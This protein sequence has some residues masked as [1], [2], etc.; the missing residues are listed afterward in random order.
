[1]PPRLALIQLLTREGNARDAVTAADAAQSALPGNLQVTSALGAAQLA[2]GNANQAVATFQRVVQA[3][4]QSAPALIR[5]AEAQAA[6]Q[7]IPNAI[8]ST[9]KAMA[10]QPNDPTAWLLLT[11]LMLVSG[12]PDDAIAEAR[13]LQ[14]EQPDRAFGYALEGE[15]LAAQK[16]WSEAAAVYQKAYARAPVAGIAA[17]TYM[18]LANAGDANGATQLADKWNAAHPKDVTLRVASA[19]MSQVR[20]DIPRAIAQYRAA[21]EVDPD[22]V[23]VLNN[24]AWLLQ[25]QG[26]QDAAARDYAE[27]AY[28][29]QPLNPSVMDTL[30]LTLLKAGDKARGTQLLRMAS[31]LDPRNSDIRLHLVQALSTSGDKSGARREAEPLLKLA[32]SA[33][34]RVEAEKVLSTL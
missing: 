29:S 27:R 31:N 20:K 5:L 12:H 11:R 28:R 34:A 3:Q 7:D 6:S 2:A 9:R 4:Q 33:T 17:R 32:P 13:K 14:K 21:L 25:E 19:Q 26:G 10:L 8:I 24:L 22:N 1:V 16:K 18:V 15:I 23:Q 30:A